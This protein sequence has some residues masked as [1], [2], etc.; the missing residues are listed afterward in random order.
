M[1]SDALKKRLDS[2]PDISPKDAEANYWKAQTVQMGGALKLA[3]AASE[4]APVVDGVD[5]ETFSAAV[6]ANTEMKDAIR[7]LCVETGV[8][9]EQPLDEVIDSVVAL[10]KSASN[11]EG[12]TADDAKSET[13]TVTADEVGSV[14][15]VLPGLDKPPADPE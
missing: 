7:R 9:P 11:G 15:D 10:V 12:E 5:E 8:D 2:I 13:E 3:L 1:F 14:T 6:E 4:G